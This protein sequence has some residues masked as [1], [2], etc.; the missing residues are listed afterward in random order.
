MLLLLDEEEE[1]SSR[2]VVRQGTDAN[3]FSGI[4]CIFTAL[5]N[6]ALTE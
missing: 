1:L 2:G 6:L 3:A 5:H 4:V